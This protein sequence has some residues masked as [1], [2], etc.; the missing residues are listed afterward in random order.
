MAMNKA[1]EKL[2]K[3][4]YKGMIYV[5][6]DLPTQTK[7]TSVLADLNLPNIMSMVN[8]LQINFL[9]HMLWGKGD[10]KLKE[11]LLEEHKISPTNSLISMVDSVCRQ[12]K[13]PEVSKMQLDK[14][15]VKR[16]VKLLDE[17]EIWLDNV[18]S[19][20]TKN[21]GLERTRLTT[22]FF[23]LTKRESQALI[24][25]CLAPLC[26]GRDELEHIKRCPF[27]K[28]SWEDSFTEDNSLGISWHWTAKGGGDGRENVFSEQEKACLRS[29][30]LNAKC[31][32]LI[33]LS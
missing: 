25:D 29:M 13:V 6:L 15:L 20:S 4:E 19:T 9:N 17:I 27:Y 31:K 24:Q 2:V 7:W 3:D 28:V 12:N 1:T 18:T 10:E 11:L 30:R 8:K 33:L 22:N 32:Q 16:R 23:K 5:I 26:S 21:V 14:A